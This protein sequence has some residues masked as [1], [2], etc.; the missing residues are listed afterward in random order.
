MIVAKK[1]PIEK[2]ESSISKILEDYADDVRDHVAEISVEI[3]KKGAQALRD[4]SREKFNVITGKYAK[5]WRAD[6]VGDTVRAIKWTN[7][8]HNTES[9]LPHLLEYGHAKRN[10]GRVAGRTHIATVEEKL[11]EEY[12]REVVS[13]L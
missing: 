5:G 2:L 10:G 9:G 4:E 1:T 8:I 13:K 3:A 7:I 11:I 12:E 6:T